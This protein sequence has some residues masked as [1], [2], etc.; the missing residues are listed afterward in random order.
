MEWLWVF[1]VSIVLWL[2]SE[3]W[4][5]L[6]VGCTT[7]GSMAFNYSLAFIGALANVLLL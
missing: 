1:N 7:K 4:A 3:I 6:L 2:L 5:V